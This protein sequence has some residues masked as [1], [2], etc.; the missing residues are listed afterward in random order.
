MTTNYTLTIKFTADRPLTQTEADF[1]C[2]AIE[3]QIDD[4]AHHD[5]ESRRAE[6]SSR[7]VGMKWDGQIDNDDNPFFRNDAG[8]I[9]VG[10]S[11]G[12]V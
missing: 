4:P 5:G 9:T 6:F 12:D 2:G 1:L 7:V 11:W 3:A 10:F 8:K